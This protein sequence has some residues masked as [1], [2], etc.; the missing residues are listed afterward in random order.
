MR[1]TDHTDYSLRTLMYLNQVQER[2]TLSEL[3]E[4]LNISRNNLIKVSNQL[5]KL[6]LV[7]TSTGRS[8]GLLLKVDARKVSLKE[9]IE[10]TEVNFYLAEC[11]PSGRSGCTFLKNCQLKHSLQKALEAFLQSLG[12][13]TLEDVTPKAH[14]AT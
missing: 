6:G 7:E 10:Q 2:V 4:K 5:A 12:G 13:V 14:R 3:S 11:F 8:G 9:I 1:L